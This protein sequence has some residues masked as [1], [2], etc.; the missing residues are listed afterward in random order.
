MDCGIALLE[1]VLRFELSNPYRSR[2]TFK[3]LSD[4]VALSNFCLRHFL[5][6]LSVREAFSNLFFLRRV[7]S[8]LSAS[9]FFFSFGITSVLCLNIC[10]SVISSSAHTA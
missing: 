8:S 1:V 9:A 4:L 5:G 2:H 6:L 7:F 10:L 3:S